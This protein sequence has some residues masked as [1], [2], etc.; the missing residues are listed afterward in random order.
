MLWLAWL[1]SAVVAFRALRSVLHRVQVS[2]GRCRYHS[3]LLYT[4][5]SGPRRE[6]HLGTTLD[7]LRHDGRRRRWL[8]A[9]LAEGLLAV[10]EDVEAGRLASGVV[11]EGTSD[12]LREETARRLGFRASRPGPLGM[13]CTLTAWMQ[14]SFV[15]TA[16]RNGPSSVRFRRVRRL[17]VQAGELLAH[18]PEIEGL[19]D[20]LAGGGAAADLEARA[21]ATAPGPGLERGWSAVP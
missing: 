10:C 7:F 8:L 21:A 19:R 11:L 14:V 6:I 16:L 1:I 20:R 13:L 2:A 4:T 9:Q 5:G 3:P 17:R 12:L 18:R 15:R